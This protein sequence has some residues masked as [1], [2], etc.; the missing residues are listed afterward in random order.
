MRTFIIAEAGVNHNGDVDIA[1]KMIDGAKE[2]GADAVKFQTFVAE[3]MVTINAPKADYQK[4][5]TGY[6][7]SQLE[8]LRN[9]QLTNNDFNELYLY[10]KNKS[11][12]FMSTP[13]DNDSAD[14]LESI[15]M[16]IFKI[17]SGEITN[18]PFLQHIAM[19]G[20]PIILSTG[21]SY[22]QEVEQAVNLIKA[23]Y[24]KIGFKAQLL[25]YP[26][27]DSP[28]L[29]QCVSAYPTVFSDVNLK[30]MKTM[31]DAFSL[32]IGFSDH[33]PGIEVSIAA[34]ALGASIIEKHF[35]LDKTMKGPDHMVSLNIEELKTMIKAIR[36]VEVALG[37]GVK[38]PSLSE[39]NN[40][41]IVRRSLVAIKSIKKGEILSS[42][43]IG[44]KRP[45]KGM[46]PMEWDNII[47]K[48]AIKYF[49][50]DDMII[51]DE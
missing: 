8:M 32:P 19:K 29:L 15:G 37:D 27:T 11:I 6:R 50:K 7:G 21:M 16:D 39:Y 2:A 5:N 51:F 36:N 38:K 49:K 41:D 9:L 24:K 43:N 26:F 40:R 35:T 34:V 30:A 47:G 1:K 22:L 28:V 18:K 4:Q 23:V 12:I 46:S 17:A 45:G 33:T 20:K 44:I 48:K 25:N 42:E 10:T 3:K 13:F 31:Q 14:L